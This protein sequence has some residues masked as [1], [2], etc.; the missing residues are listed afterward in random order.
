M[1]FMMNGCK[2]TLMMF[3]RVQRLVGNVCF[4]RLERVRVIIFGVGGVGSWTAESL[5]RSGIV[6]L[7]I[8]DA[9]N[10]AE[11]N[12]NR[13]IMA[14]ST[15]VGQPKVEV[16]RQRLLDINPCADIIALK[17]IYTDCTAHKFELA[18][19]D[20]VIDAIDSL[21]DKALL[22]LNATASKVKLFS[23]MGAALKLDP[24]RISVAEFWKVKGCP[25]AAALRNKFKRSGIM[26][27]R[28]F[29]C[30]YSD[31]LVPNSTDAPEDTSG[32]MSFNKARING[33]LCH[34]T[35]IFGFVLAGLVIEDIVKNH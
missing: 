14:T 5:V 21:S 13:Q 24:T 26:P 34:I 8:V 9:D 11:S 15:T 10:V 27:R 2:S 1:I 6:H 30:V 4:E 29:K 7:T 18:D 16:L 25:L 20:Y 23:S 35:A 31:E 17:D 32:A 33:A 3:N 19:Y 12:I 28:K 22:I